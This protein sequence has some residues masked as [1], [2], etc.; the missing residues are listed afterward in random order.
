[1]PARRSVELL[2]KFGE[3]IKNTAKWQI[4][5]SILQGFTR[6]IR[7]AF[8]YAQDLNKTLTD[9]KIVSELNNEEL[10][11]FAKTANKAARRLSTTTKEY[12]KASLIFF[13]Q[14]LSNEE[15]LERTDVVIKMANVTP[16]KARPWVIPIFIPCFILLIFSAPIA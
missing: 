8:S 10:E 2:N 16:K 13:Q 4:S 1:M 5:S 12:A 7:E 11:Q 6:S 3:S 9:I 15:V 14:G